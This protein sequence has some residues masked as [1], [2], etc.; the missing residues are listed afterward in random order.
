MTNKSQMLLHLPRL[1]HPGSV[2]WPSPRSRGSETCPGSC[3]STEL[4][5]ECCSVPRAHASCLVPFPVIP[6]SL[7]ALAAGGN[8]C[9]RGGRSLGWQEAARKRREAPC[10]ALPTSTTNLWLPLLSPWH[11]TPCPQHPTSPSLSHYPAHPRAGVLAVRGFFPSPVA[12]LP[13]P[14]EL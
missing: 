10:W 8:L 6:G 1:D 9:L 7:L 2:N 3:A 5:S 11:C 12:K 13:S 14:S 4:C